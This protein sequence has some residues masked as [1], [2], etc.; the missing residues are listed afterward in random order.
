MPPILSILK[1]TVIGLVKAGN[2]VEEVIRHFHWT[3][4][5]L[6]EFGVEVDIEFVIKALEGIFEKH[7]AGRTT[8]A[9]K[10]ANF[11]PNG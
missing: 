7:S 5:L 8:H 10:Y 9:K 11:G 1:D 2:P 6:K 4:A 3:E